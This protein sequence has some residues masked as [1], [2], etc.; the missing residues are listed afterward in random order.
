MP[1]AL[2]SDADLVKAVRQGELPEE[3][4]DKACLN[5]LQLVEKGTKSDQPGIK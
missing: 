2:D 5:I 1:A 4:L 3:Q